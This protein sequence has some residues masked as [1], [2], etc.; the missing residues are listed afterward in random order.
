MLIEDILLI[1]FGSGI[2]FLFIVRPVYKFVK[3]VIPQRKDSLQEAKERLEAARRDLE[4][5]KL[6]EEAEKLY[7]K[8]YKETLEEDASSELEEENKNNRSI[9]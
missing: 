2:S 1:L 8:M 4:A 6:N 7:A 5:A 3:A 9:R